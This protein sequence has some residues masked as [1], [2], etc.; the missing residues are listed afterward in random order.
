M[1]FYD[2]LNIKDICSRKNFIYSDTDSIKEYDINDRIKYSLYGIYFEDYNSLY[3]LTQ[4]VYNWKNADYIKQKLNSI[5]GRKIFNK[6]ENKTMTNFQ[7]IASSEERAKEFITDADNQ[8]FRDFYNKYGI[9]DKHKCTVSDVFD[10]LLKERVPP[11]TECYDL[12]KLIKF[13]SNPAL[14]S[15]DETTDIL[16][17]IVKLDNFRYHKGYGEYSVAVKKDNAIDI[18][19]NGKLRANRKSL[20]TEKLKDLPVIK[21][22]L[23]D[24]A[25]SV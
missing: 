24:A 14:F 4:R 10:W 16:F 8:Y 20:V 12:Y 2:H 11:K 15:S 3:D 9:E 23:N 17:Y 1:Q 5:Y 13:V 22:D 21:L 18:I 25:R 19:F 7:W 6:K